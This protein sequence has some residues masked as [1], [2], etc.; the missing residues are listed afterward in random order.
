MVVDR[1]R[2]L[3]FGMAATAFTLLPVTAVAEVATDLP[4]PSFIAEAKRAIALVDEWRRLGDELKEVDAALKSMSRA[5]SRRSGYLVRVNDLPIE[6]FRAALIADDALRSTMRMKIAG[7]KEAAIR[8][9]LL[10]SLMEMT[11]KQP[12]VLKREL[13][14]AT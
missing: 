7:R 11:G 10:L 4:Q 9:T 6:R 3:A 2:V 5:D 8:D 1:R 12:P 14:L 13:G